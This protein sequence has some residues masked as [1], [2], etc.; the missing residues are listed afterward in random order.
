ML[1]TQMFVIVSAFNEQEKYAEMFDLYTIRNDK[2]PQI[3]RFSDIWWD[4]Y[5]FIP[6]FGF[7]FQISHKL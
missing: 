3:F 7:T 5:K 6:H 1:L 4:F 2:M